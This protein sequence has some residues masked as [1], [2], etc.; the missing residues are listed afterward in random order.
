MA[1]EKV[2]ALEE[3]AKPRLRISAPIAVVE[4]KGQT[5]KAFRTYRLRI[6]NISTSVVRSCYAKQ[7]SFINING[8][9]SDSIGMHFKKSTEQPYELINYSHQQSFDI[10]PLGHEIIDIVS[11]DETTPNNN[12]IMLYATQGHG[13]AHVRNSIPQRFFPHDLTIQFCGD[14]IT[15]VEEKYKLHI[16]R[17]EILE[18]DHEINSNIPYRSVV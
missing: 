15:P 6:E 7:T 9:E 4:P 10:P 18:M 17:E 1:I 16:N 12:V 2:E 13:S 3:A 11:I 5:G 14:N 8:H